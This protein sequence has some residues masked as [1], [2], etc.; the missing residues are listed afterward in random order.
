LLDVHGSLVRT[1][2]PIM[3][4]GA[5]AMSTAYDCNGNNKSVNISLFITARN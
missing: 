3:P 1:V 5:I 4:L 2:M